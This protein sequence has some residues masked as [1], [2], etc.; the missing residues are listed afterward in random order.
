MQPY[1]YGEKKMKQNHL[2]KY[3]HLV[4]GLYREFGEYE[5]KPFVADGERHALFRAHLLELGVADTRV[6]SIAEAF[7]DLWDALCKLDYRNLQIV[8]REFE[9]LATLCKKYGEIEGMRSDFTN[10]KGE[11][12][13]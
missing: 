10:S 6:K 13:K 2:E 4:S 12:Y 7:G 9:G 8:C 5:G 3:D 11:E 1:N